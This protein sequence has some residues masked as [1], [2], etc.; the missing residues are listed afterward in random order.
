MA[1]QATKPEEK[2]ATEIP[3]NADHNRARRALGQRIGEV[4]ELF[5]SREEALKVAQVS[6]MQ[7][8]R[9]ISKAGQVPL[10]PIA[11]LAQVKGIRLDWI[12][13]GEGPKHK[14]DDSDRRLLVSAITA[15]LELQTLAEKHGALVSLSNRQLGELTHGVYCLAQKVGHVPDNDDLLGLFGPLLG[16]SVPTSQS[17]ESRFPGIALTSDV[18]PV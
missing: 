12:W 1:P 6:R 13:S 10:E 16:V 14:N 5:P 7:L 2:L 17:S 11:K 15:V 3:D 8:H 18:R 9:Y 4:V